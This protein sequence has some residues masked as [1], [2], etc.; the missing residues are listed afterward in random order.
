MEHKETKE[1]GKPRNNWFTGSQGTKA[2]KAIR[3]SGIN[4]KPRNNWFNWSQGTRNNCS[5][6]SQETKKSGNKEL[7]VKWSTRKP[8][9]QVH[10]EQEICFSQ[11]QTVTG[12]KTFG[13]I[14]G[15][16]GKLILA[17]STSGSTI[18]NAA[19]IAGS[20]TVTLP[21][22]TIQSQFLEQHKP[23]PIIRH[24]KIYLYSKC[25]YCCR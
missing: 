3:Q 9:N 17:G 10:K 23:L 11:V 16:V 2:I 8:G 22:S 12:A 13:T 6:G 19:A 7:L 21:G 24:F 4:W 14:G 1:S 5:T 15:A 25:H 20:T 18:L